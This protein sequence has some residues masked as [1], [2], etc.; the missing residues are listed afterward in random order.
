MLTIWR[1]HTA[2]CANRNKGRE[3]LKCTCPLWADGYV[4]GKR[5][6]RVSLKTRDMA[7]ARK[8]AVALES[9]DAIVCRPLDEAVAAY[10]VNCQHLNENTQRKYCNRLRKQLLPFC[11]SRGI[12]YVSELSVETLDS[13]RAGRKLAVTTSARELDTLRQ[14]LAFCQK[15]R[16]IGDNPA[17]EIDPPRN[18]K[19]TPI[20]PYTEQEITSIVEAAGKIGKTDYERLRARAAILLMRNT[21][22]RISDVALLERSRIQNGSLLLHTKKTGGT[23]LLPLPDDLLAALRRV[24]LP[25]GSEPGTSKHF[26]I[27]GRG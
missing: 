13:F 19:P 2:A 16:W 12:D 22:L 27:N 11:E 25:H 24:P 14:F 6:L 15:R 18:A 5:T 9:D 7:R 1:R 4:N 21:G 8:K 3:H 10:L 20:V 26:F 17:K 23:V